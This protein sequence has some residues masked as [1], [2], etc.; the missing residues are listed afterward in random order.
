MQGVCP[1]NHSM[2]LPLNR[3]WRE[4]RNIAPHGLGSESSVLLTIL[5]STS[6]VC[7]GGGGTVL[8]GPI[9]YVSILKGVTALGPEVWT[10]TPLPW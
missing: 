5:S 3:S 8:R 9:A 10:H 7:V 2:R 1:L 4:Y 6:L